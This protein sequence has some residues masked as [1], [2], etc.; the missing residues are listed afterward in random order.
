MLHDEETYPDPSTFKPERFLTTNKTTGKLELDP[1]V[2]DPG[3]MAFGFGR[4]SV[5]KFTVHQWRRN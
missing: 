2:R 5:L 1:N 4:R 3:L